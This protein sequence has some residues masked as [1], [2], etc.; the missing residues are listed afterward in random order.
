MIAI[1]HLK[2]DVSPLLAIVTFIVLGSVIIHGGTISLF[3]MGL[4]THCTWKSE[5]E[6]RRALNLSLD[7]IHEYSDLNIKSRVIE[8]ESLK[9]K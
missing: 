6:A 5:R 2:V 3:E 1:V 8:T 9:P 4:T 7:I